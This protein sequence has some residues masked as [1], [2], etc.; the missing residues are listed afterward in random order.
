MYFHGL[1]DILFTVDQSISVHHHVIKILLQTSRHNA[2]VLA[3][4]AGTHPHCSHSAQL[5][6]GI[7]EGIR[8]MME[9]P[10]RSSNSHPTPPLLRLGV[11]TPLIDSLSLFPFQ[12]SLS[13]LSTQLTFPRTSSSSRSRGILKSVGYI[14]TVWPGSTC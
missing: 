12:E 2:T 9:I 3:Q 11:F 1:T 10:S 7:E 14:P 5:V 8:Q 13:F 6:A 4:L